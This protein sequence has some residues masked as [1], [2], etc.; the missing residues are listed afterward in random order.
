MTVNELHQTLS[1]L[2]DDTRKH[3][4]QYQIEFSFVENPYVLYLPIPK[5]ARSRELESNLDLRYCD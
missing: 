4:S 2:L 3:K 5:R 1:L